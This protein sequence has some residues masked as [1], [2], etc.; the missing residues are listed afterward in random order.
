MSSLTTFR[1]TANSKTNGAVTVSTEFINKSRSLDDYIRQHI[2]DFQYI[3][4]ETLHIESNAT[5]AGMQ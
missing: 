4:N 2:K 5:F 1:S 3:G